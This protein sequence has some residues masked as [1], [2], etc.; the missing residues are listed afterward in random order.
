MIK[1][2]SPPFLSP[3]LFIL[4][5]M[6]LPTRPQRRVAV[7]NGPPAVQACAQDTGYLA[8]AADARAGTGRGPGACASR[9]RASNSAASSPSTMSPFDV[10]AREIV[11]L[12]GPNGAGKSTTFN[13][14]TGV[15]PRAAGQSRSSASKSRWQRRRSGQARGRPHLPARQAGARHDRAGERRDRRAF[16]RRL[17]ARSRA[18]CG[19]IAPTKRGCSRKPHGRSSVSGSP[20]RSTSLRLALARPAAHCR[21]CAG[22]VRR[23]DAAAARRAGGGPAPPGEAAAGCAAAAIARRR[24]VG[25]VGRTRHGLCDGSCRPHRSARFRHQDA[26]RHAYVDKKQSRRDQ[27]LSRSRRMS[28]LLEV[29]DVHIAYGKVEA[30][31]G[32]AERRSNEIVTI[33]GANGAGKTT[34]LNAV[35]GVLPLTGRAN[36][37]APISRR[38]TS[39]TASRRA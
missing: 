3:L 30:V 29:A 15:L 31:R 10:Q 5:V 39:R 34:L 20:T 2:F 36:F 24:H 1:R 9:R 4:L 38:S 18:C 13:L 16:A 12:I 11:A 8:D 25:A 21:D 27:G 14:I 32:V 33:I 37:P 19:S 26:R 23:S 35:M 22:A 17:P 7:A 28:A 6:L